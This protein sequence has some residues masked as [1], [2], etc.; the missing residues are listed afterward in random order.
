[1]SDKRFI[2]LEIKISHQEVLL[3]ELHQVV[4]QQ[5][6]TIHRLE[7]SLKLLSKRFQDAVGDGAEIASIEK[8]PHY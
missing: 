8:P 1:M 7:K 2:D 4:Y 5:Q 3:E 6:E